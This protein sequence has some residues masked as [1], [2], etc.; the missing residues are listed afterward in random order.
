[1]DREAQREELGDPHDTARP[2]FGPISY[3]IGSVD[4]PDSS[5]ESS[6]ESSVDS[7]GEDR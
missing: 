3:E 2:K 1:L 6:V 7:P 5:V 4:D